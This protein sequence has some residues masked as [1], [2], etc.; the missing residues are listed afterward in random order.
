MLSSW[1]LCSALFSGFEFQVATVISLSHSLACV[2]IVT[3]PD[4]ISL[5]M[6]ALRAAITLRHSCWGLLGLGKEQEPR[7][8]TRLRLRGDIR[9]SR[10]G[11]R[12]H[13]FSIPSSPLPL[14]S[15]ALGAGPRTNPPEEDSGPRLE[16]PRR[17]LAIGNGL[18]VVGSCT[19]PS[20][21]GEGP[22]P[23]AIL[24]VHSRNRG[25]IS[26]T[27][28]FR[29]NPGKNPFPPTTTGSLAPTQPRLLHR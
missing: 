22:P 8:G 25:Q 13:P 16:G 7:L 20:A 6:L 10:R 3:N 1:F 11:V 15:L 19:P 24:P 14:Y 23:I 27:D 21:S 5:Y 4:I 26:W 9:L 18:I 29:G 12:C 28:G 17:I 2:S